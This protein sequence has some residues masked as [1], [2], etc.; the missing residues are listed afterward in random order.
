MGKVFEERSTEGIERDPWPP[1]ISHMQGGVIFFAGRG[2][3]IG[4][5]RN[6]SW[7]SRLARRL[8]RKL[9]S[10]DLNGLTRRR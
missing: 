8:G 6:S 10:T 2:D 3:A 1:V 4:T 9:A 7:F 5:G